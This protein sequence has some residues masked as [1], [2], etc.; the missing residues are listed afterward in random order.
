MKETYVEINLDNLEKNVAEI[1]KKYSSYNYFIG[2]IKTDAYGLGMK[3]VNS[4]VRGGV[5]YLAVSYLEEALDVRKENDKVPVLCLQPIDLVNINIAI[6]NNITLTIP[7]LEYLEKL[8]K[9]LKKKIKV[10]IKIDSG[11]NRLGF[12]TK[13]ELENAVDII[14]NNKYIELEGIYTHFATVGIIDKHFDAS[15]NRFERLLKNIDLSKVK[16]IH[17]GGSTVVM[18]HPKKDFINGFRS[19]ILIPGYNVSFTESNDGIA[20]K[21]R[22]IRNNIYKSVLNISDSIK[23]VK[24]NIKPAVSMYTYINQIK[25]VKAGEYIGYGAS[26]KAKQN[27]KIAILPIGYANGIGKENLGR[28]VVINKNRCY[29]VGEIG[30]NMMCIKVDDKV[31][32][33]DKVEILGKNITLGML[34]RFNNSTLAEMLI[35]IGRNNQRKYIKK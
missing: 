23:N 20:N 10:H 13:E 16:I 14:E 27:M 1:K 7:D 29:V 18:S 3:V 21:I 9:L 19:G 11:M 4:L 12:K 6:K 34:S 35:N 26:Y 5:D 31:K 33:N 28:F 15:M 25:E 30:M 8:S 22:F 24:I 17:I 2:V 32:I